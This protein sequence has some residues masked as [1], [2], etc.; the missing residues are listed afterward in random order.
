[1]QNSRWSTNLAYCGWTRDYFHDISWK[2][3]QFSKLY[4][5]RLN[6]TIIPSMLFTASRNHLKYN[7]FAPSDSK[8]YFYRKQV[9]FASAWHLYFPENIEH[10]VLTLE[11]QQFYVI[12]TLSFCTLLIPKESDWRW[13]FPLHIAICFN[14]LHLLSKLACWVENFFVISKKKNAG[15]SWKLDI[16]SPGNYWFHCTTAQVANSVLIWKWKVCITRACGSGNTPHL[17]AAK[18]IMM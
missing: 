12:L 8:C 14:I 7:F 4:R 15:H 16:I 13:A 1:M 5:L 17:E 11:C 3:F 18:I 6:F 9:A 10:G 2:S